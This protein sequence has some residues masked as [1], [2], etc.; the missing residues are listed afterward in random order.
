MKKIITNFSTKEN[1]SFIYSTMETPAIIT[2]EKVIKNRL[3]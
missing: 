1:Q 2:M 3:I